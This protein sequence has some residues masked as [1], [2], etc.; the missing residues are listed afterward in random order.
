[1]KDDLSIYNNLFQISLL[2]FKELKPSEIDILIETVRD[3]K[4]EFITFELIEYNKKIEPIETILKMIS[5]KMNGD[6]IV[7][8]HNKD[9][10]V[11]GKIK[12][13]NFMFKKV[14]DLIDFD[15]SVENKGKFIK[16]IYESDETIYIGKDGKEEK[17]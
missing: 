11:L 10:I 6:F 9:G 12:F 2:S 7:D 1:M 3:V 17:L 14:E 13:K 4:K 8:I 16:V 15:M 5:N